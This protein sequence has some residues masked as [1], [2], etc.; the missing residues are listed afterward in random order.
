LGLDPVVGKPRAK[1][2]HK[3]CAHPIWVTRNRIGLGVN[4]ERFAHLVPGKHNFF[5]ASDEAFYP[6]ITHVTGLAKLRVDHRNGTVEKL[7]I[8][9]TQIR[10]RK[11]G[12]KQFQLPAAKIRGDGLRI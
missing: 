4:Q 10:H 1:R 11:R 2:R 12:G 6:E 9:S 5:I 3:H 8:D 7:R